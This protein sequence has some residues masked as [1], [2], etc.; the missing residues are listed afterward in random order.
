MLR[1]N[2]PDVVCAAFRYAFFHGSIRVLQQNNEMH[3]SVLTED[4]ARNKATQF[5]FE[6]ALREVQSEIP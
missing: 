1:N 6:R 3:N 4:E 5:F 2:Q